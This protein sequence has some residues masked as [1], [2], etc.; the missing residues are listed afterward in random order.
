[1][2]K[3]VIAIDGKEVMDSFTKKETNLEEV[4]ALL[5]RLKQIEHELI[6]MEFDDTEIR[7]GADDEKT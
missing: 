2:I 7:Y 6:N 1:M 3:I 5:L 4:G